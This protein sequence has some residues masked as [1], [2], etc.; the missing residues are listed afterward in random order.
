MTTFGLGSFLS[1]LNV[2]YRDFRYVI[3]FLVQFLLFLA[4]VIYP[5]SIIPEGWMRET[6]QIL[7][8][9][10]GAIDTFRAAFSG[11]GI[12]YVLAGKSFFVSLLFSVIG[13]AYFRKTEH[14]FADLA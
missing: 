1:A 3:P 12:D 13:M 2:K 11:A 14:Y 4:P 6:V 5:V 7:N 9:M 10:A 8:P